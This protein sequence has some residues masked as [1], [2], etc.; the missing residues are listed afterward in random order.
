[1]PRSTLPCPLG[2]HLSR[3][4]LAH[5]RAMLEEQRE[6]RLDQLTALRRPGSRRLLGAG[7]REIAVALTVAA[8]SVLTD[9]LTA[10][11]RM[12]EGSYGACEQCGGAID[13]E[14]LAVLPQAALC[15]TC[16]TGT[17]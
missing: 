11:R 16:Q 10:L 15:L 5:L 1:M 2:G 9:V 13:P 12:D 8:Q 17:P 14:R 7:S 3:G 6:F 4:Q